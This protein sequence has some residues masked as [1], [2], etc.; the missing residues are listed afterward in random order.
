MLPVAVTEEETELL[1]YDGTVLRTLPK[2]TAMHIL[3]SSGTVGNAE[4][5]TF[6]HVCLPKGELGLTMDVTGEYGYVKEDGLTIYANTLNWNY[7]TT[8]APQ[9]DNG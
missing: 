1:A 5:G 6:Y 3:G 9:Y 7:N 2:G 4:N 8:T